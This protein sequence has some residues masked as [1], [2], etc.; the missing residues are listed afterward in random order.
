MV[1]TIKLDPQAL[2]SVPGTGKILFTR[3]AIEVIP[4]WPEGPL[5]ELINGEL[6]M[7]PSPSITHQIISA[8]RPI[9]SWK[10]SRVIA[11]GI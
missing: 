11:N 3:D 10:S 7:A 8:N 9:S 4:E 2:Q 6:F 5:V 1:L